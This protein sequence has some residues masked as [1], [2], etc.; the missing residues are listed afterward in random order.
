MLPSQEIRR[1]APE[2][3]PLRIGTGWNKEDLDKVQ[4]FIESTYGDSHPGSGHLDRLVEQARRG[5]REAGGHGARYFCTDICDGESQGHDGINYSLAS[6]EMI[7]NM[8]E[9]QGRAT[10]FDAG[11]F[12]ASCDKGLPGNLMGLARLNIP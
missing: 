4:V 6:R 9:I 7:A 8:I 2:L 1:I 11:V 3:D 5:I 10:P 12:I